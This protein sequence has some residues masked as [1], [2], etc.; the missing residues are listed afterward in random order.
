MNDDAEMFIGSLSM[1]ET[2]NLHQLAE[3]RSIAYHQAIAQRLRAN[4]ELLDTVR[5]RLQSQLDSE[6]HPPTSSSQRHWAQVWSELIEQPI[7][8][9]LEFMLERSDKADQLRQSTPFAGI[10]TPAERWAIH[11]IVREQWLEQ[12]PNDSI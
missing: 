1:T 3:L 4:P 9:L 11:R 10:L 7:D 2:Q 6:A 5:Q 12:L 8:Q